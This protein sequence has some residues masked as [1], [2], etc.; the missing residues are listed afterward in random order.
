MGGGLTLILQRI[1]VGA[2]ER[3]G[4]HTAHSTAWHLWGS[5]IG[6]HLQ[7]REGC[8]SVL[9]PL[10]LR[11]GLSAVGTG[12][13][14]GW[15]WHSALCGCAEGCGQERISR[16]TGL[17]KRARECPCKSTCAKEPLENYVLNAPRARLLPTLV[18]MQR[19]SCSLK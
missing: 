7:R 8:R 12:G 6:A 18:L 13:A 2:G 16:D 11:C 4:P 15:G 5:V 10:A 19:L 9:V 1:R 3:D 14:R 17:R